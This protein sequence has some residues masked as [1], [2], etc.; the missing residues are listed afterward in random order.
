MAFPAGLKARFP[1]LKV[2]GF[3]HKELQVCVANL[4]RLVGDLRATHTGLL[5]LRRGILGRRF[6]LHSVL[7]VLDSLAQAFANVGEL[8]GTEDQ[9]RND[10]YDNPIEWTERVRKLRASKHLAF[11]RRL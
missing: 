4:N 11:Q 1:G 9:Q 10:E 3:H 6:A 5:L 8:A 2:W 7:K